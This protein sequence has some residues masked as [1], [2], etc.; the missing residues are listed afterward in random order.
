MPKTLPLS[1]QTI[2]SLRNT[3]S[4]LYRQQW[5]IE[6]EIFRR[7]TTERFGDQPLNRYVGDVT[8]THAIELFAPDKDAAEQL[9]QDYGPDAFDFLNWS[10]SPLTK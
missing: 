5:D 3:E 10:R 7:E 1:E 2:L 6:R 4:R 9:I 8:V